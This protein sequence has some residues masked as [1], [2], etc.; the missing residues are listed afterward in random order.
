MIKNGVMKIVNKTILNNVNTMNTVSTIKISQL[1]KSFD[2]LYRIHKIS[3]KDSFNK[4][5]FKVNYLYSVV[6]TKEL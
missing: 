1:S 3:L 5:N 4:L 6:E 2:S